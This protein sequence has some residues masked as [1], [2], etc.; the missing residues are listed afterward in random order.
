MVSALA[1]YRKFRFEQHV[2]DIR[3]NHKRRA[4][5]Y[6]LLENYCQ[7]ISSLID[8]LHR[9]K[10]RKEEDGDSEYRIFEAILDAIENENISALEA[11]ALLFPRDEIALIESASTRG[12]VHKGFARA[13]FIA[14]KRAEAKSAITMALAYPA[15][16]I[17]STVGL[18][19]FILDKTVPEMVR[20]LPVRQWPDWTQFLHTMYLVLVEYN[21]LVLVWLLALIAFMLVTLK[22]KRGR[23]RNILDK[24]P[25]WSIQKRI[26]GSV[27]LIALGDLI[28]NGDTFPRAVRRLE[29]YSPEYLGSYL[30]VMIA[31][32]ENN[33]TV[34]QALDCGL[35][36]RNTTGYIKDFS[37]LKTFGTKVIQIGEKALDETVSFIKILAVTIG[38]L[39]V[40]FAAGANGYIALSSNAVQKAFITEIKR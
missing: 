5:L 25:P 7:S 30:D 18:F 39:G 16:I 34:P 19:Y 13:K 36:S 28:S 6:D 8:V 23:L 21:I 14:E 9:I 12:Q 38:L 11:M 31:R 37:H 40:I 3:A 1:W 4:A 35:F 33:D 29:E 32:M 24:I 15:Y 26:Q 22:F 27:F 17:I 10:N 2:S 20:F